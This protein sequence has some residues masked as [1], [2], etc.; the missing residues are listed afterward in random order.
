M[1][2]PST[3]TYIANNSFSGSNTRD[4]D[5]SKNAY[6]RQRISGAAALPKVGSTV[7]KGNLVYKYTKSTASG[8]TVTVAKVKSKSVKSISIPASISVGGRNYSVTAINAKAFQN[9]KKLK[10]VTIGKNVKTIGKNA[11]GNCKKLRKITIKTSKLTK[12]SVKANAFKGVNKKVSVKVP[13]K[14]LKAYKKFLRK[15]GLGK[16]AKIRK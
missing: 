11:F 10:S 16:K 3:V 6:A 2:I 14:K 5:T 12:S 7:T 13:K 8:G 1:V 4:I 9:C 15:K